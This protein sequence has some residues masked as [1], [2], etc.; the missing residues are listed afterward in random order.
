M[1]SHSVGTFLAVLLLLG[2]GFLAL[3]ATTGRRR[4]LAH[5]DART[6][7]ALV[8][9]GATAAS[10]YFSEV[11][12]FVPCELCWYQRIAMYPLAVI[13]PIAAARRDA[14]ADIYVR[15]IAGVGLLIALYHVQLQAFP[16]QGSFC[17][18]AAPCTASPLEVLGFATIPMMSAASF[19]GIL[20][21][22][23][24]P[25]NPLERAPDADPARDE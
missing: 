24:I 20:A 13:V 14:T 2:A 17:T 3:A 5:D 1:S 18:A 7:A 12:G 9:G 11:A 25:F 22:T 8:A 4:W 19:A 6:I 23:V 15:V 16:S 10:L 21:L